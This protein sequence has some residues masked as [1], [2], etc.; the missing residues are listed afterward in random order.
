MSD[1]RKNNV[2]RLISVLVMATI[3]LAVFPAEEDSIPLL[4][5]PDVNHDGEVNLLDII[6]VSRSLGE[7]VPEPI[8]DPEIA[9][10]RAEKSDLNLQIAELSAEINRLEENARLQEESIANLQR[11]N[12]ALES[13]VAELLTEVG[14]LGEDVKLQTE[15]NASLQAE[16]NDLTEQ[17]T[18]LT[19][20]ID[21]LNE[22]LAPSPVQ[23]KVDVLDFQ[24]KIT[25]Q[26]DIFWQFSW[27]LTLANNT[28]EAVEVDADILFLDSDGF[29]VS[30]GYGFDLPLAIGESK[31]F[32]DTS[33]IG[34]EIASEVV[35]YEVELEW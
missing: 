31:I 13:Q 17:I 9:A 19:A 21:R 11:E 5:S 32:R 7:P 29:I 30:S 15:T 28:G 2:I 14:S 16:N 1:K 34:T 25:Q 27:N 8:E 12:E 22:L 23:G 20:E 35:E 10:L 6:I 18:Q 3:A 4:N 26:N 33:L 24:V